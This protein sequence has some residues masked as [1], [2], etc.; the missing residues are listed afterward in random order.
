MNKRPSTSL[1]VQ[2]PSFELEALQR[3]EES[4]LLAIRTC[5]AVFAASFSLQELF[6]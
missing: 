2:D 5:P 3:T 4:L 1:V 6:L